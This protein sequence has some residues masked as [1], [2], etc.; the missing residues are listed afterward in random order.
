MKWVWILF[1]VV[2]ILIFSLLILRKWHPRDRVVSNGANLLSVNKSI[3]DFGEIREG[4]II[5]ANFILSN[6]SK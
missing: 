2:L 1:G 5:Q 4:E 3:V 6:L